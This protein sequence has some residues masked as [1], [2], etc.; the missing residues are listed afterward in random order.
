MTCRE[1]AD[2]ILDYLAGTLPDETRR[3]FDHHLTICPNCVRYLATY[4]S[5]VELGRRAF[6]DDDRRAREAGVPE[7]LIA[8]I[9]AARRG[10]TQ[11]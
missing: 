9:L 10:P 11:A 6:E 2:F 5:T 7:E 1:L 3:I 4:R 8:A